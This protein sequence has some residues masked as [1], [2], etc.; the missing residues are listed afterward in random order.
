MTVILKASSLSD[1]DDTAASELN[2]ILDIRIIQQQYTVTM[3]V[4]VTV[5]VTVAVTVFSIFNKSR[6]FAGIRDPKEI[7]WIQAS[8][9]STRLSLCACNQA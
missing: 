7:H 6:S 8:G 1:L 5:T 3:T 9:I 2:L 4:T